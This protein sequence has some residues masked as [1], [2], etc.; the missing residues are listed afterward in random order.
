[1]REVVLENLDVQLGHLLDALQDVQA[2]AAAVALQR[3]G[4]IGDQLQFAQHELR[5]DQTSVQ[6]TGFDD[7]GDAAVDDDA[8]IEDLK[9]LAGGLL[10]AERP[11]RAPKLSISPL[12]AP[13][14]RPT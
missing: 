6:K 7:V 5:D 8:G 9:R 12:L 13:T 11:P 3:I 1:M 10:A 2:A 14:T 4:R